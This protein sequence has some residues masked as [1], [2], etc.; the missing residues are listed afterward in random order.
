MLRAYRSAFM[1]TLTERWTKI[2]DL[3]ADLRIP[4]AL[5]IAGLIW[6]GFFPQAVVRMVTPTFRT[7]FTATK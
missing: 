4:V 2:V 1:G 6:L 5:L 3:A 7:Y